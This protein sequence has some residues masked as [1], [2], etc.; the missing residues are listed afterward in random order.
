MTSL[1]FPTGHQ[2]AWKYFS[3]SASHKLP[4]DHRQLTL[5]IQNWRWI[6]Y[7]SVWSWIGKDIAVVWETLLSFP[8]SK[9]CWIYQPSIILCQLI[10]WENTVP[11]SAHHQAGVKEFCSA[12][13]RSVYA[14]IWATATTCCSIILAWRVGAL[15]WPGG[16]IPQNICFIIII[17]LW[18]AGWTT[19]SDF[20]AT[21]GAKHEPTIRDF[22]CWSLKRRRGG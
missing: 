16:K 5:S 15:T 17:L 3:T 7:C 13:Q 4:S 2:P 10:I 6:T 20:K 1:A 8:I 9:Y 11:G 14:I 21:K 18:L 19:F 22:E 12:V